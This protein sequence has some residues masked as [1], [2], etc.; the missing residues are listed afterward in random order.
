MPPDEAREMISP[1]P[2]ALAMILRYHSPPRWFMR[3]KVRTRREV[4]NRHRQS[5]AIL[6]PR[7]LGSEGEL[8]RR[9]S[10]SR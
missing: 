7:A 9:I 2:L 4:G 8:V 10:S 5:R 6:L 1:R 3:R